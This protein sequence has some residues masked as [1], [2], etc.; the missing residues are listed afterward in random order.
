MAANT[1]KVS[2]ALQTL[3]DKGLLD[4]LP[5]S[6]AAF[7]FDQMKDWDLLFSAEHS[8]FERLFGLLDRS[9]PQEV[10][11]IFQPM[12]ELEPRMGMNDK[13][14]PR[15]Q[16]TLEQVDFLNRNPRY[17]EW[18]AAVS[19]VFAQL[20][21][22]LDA[23]I[24]R[25]GHA[26]L[27][28]VI[29]P[30]Q[31]PADPSRMWTR[32][33]G[34]GRRITVEAPERA[35][36]FLALLLTGQEQGRGAPTI[37][38]LFAAGKKGGAHSSWVVESGAGVSRLGG[39]S[40]LVVK[41]S[42]QGLDSYRKRLMKE[43]QSV[44]DAR[45]IAGPRQLSARLKEMKILASEGEAARDSILAEFA[46]AILL[47]GNGTLLINNT[48]VEWATVQAVR[49]ARPG[50]AVVSFGIRNKVKPFSS[51][52]I[53]A[54]QDATNP[55]PS[56]MDTLGTYVDL[57][58]FYQYIW[59]EFEKYAEYRNNT[60]YLFVGDGMEEMLA[61]GPPD[62]P[63]LSASRPMKVAAVFGHLKDWLGV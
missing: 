39:G 24:A 51:L 14:W 8:Y 37:G 28:I 42:Y 53:Y 21:P 60:V 54:D 50:L 13:T 45:E 12:R 36:E 40:P 32:L 6:F 38:E 17:P 35:E 47:S 26:R 44:V 10:E 2:P 34:K 3:I 31:L 41:Y 56:Q 49:R 58:I 43:V 23:E 11:R 62:F 19:Q 30:S 4:R 59:Q 16:F 29:A 7:C 48:F 18:R 25:S 20:D 5:R 61:I 27:A 52:L 22:V 1:P 9:S 33:Q 15:G 57:E 63:L 55:I 46:R